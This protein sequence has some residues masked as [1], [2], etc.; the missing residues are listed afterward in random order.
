MREEPIPNPSKSDP[1][2]QKPAAEATKTPQ[3]PPPPK[4]DTPADTR[5]KANSHNGEKNV[6]ERWK[7]GV[8]TLTLVAVVWY[9]CIASHQLTQM[10]KATKATQD[11][12]IAAQSAATT[13]ASQLE[14]AERPWV[15]ASISLN[16]PLTFNVNGAN[17]PLKIVLR[18]TGHSPAQ[19]T[20]ISPLPLIGRGAFNAANNIQDVCQSA[21]K[22]AALGIALFPNV[23]FEQ[24]ENVGLGKEDI[25]KAKAPIEFPGSHWGEVFLSPTVV[26][27]ITYS[28]Q[29]SNQNSVYHTAYI[30][31]LLKI[32][33]ANRLSDAFKIGEDVDQKHLLLRLHVEEPITAN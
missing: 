16:G 29:Y 22:S 1:A 30:V 7:V 9:A 25:E 12:A 10:R 23:N 11:A 13:A 32:D 15:D 21:S 14:L 5:D 2:A 6:R 24:R 4:T 33:S 8:E 18:N 19:F 17:I 26:I 28:N 3:D 31:D 27:C 20:S